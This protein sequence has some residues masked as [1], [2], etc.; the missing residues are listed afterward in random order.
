[1][2]IVC[3]FWYQYFSRRSINIRPIS[4]KNCA[5]RYLIMTESNEEF[6]V[7]IE[8]ILYKV[9]L[10]INDDYRYLQWTGTITREI[11]RIGSTRG[12]Y[13]S[14]IANI[15][16]GVAQIMWTCGILTIFD[17]RCAGAR[18]FPSYEIILCKVVMNCV[19]EFLQQSFVLPNKLKILVSYYCGENN[20]AQVTVL[21][22]FSI[23]CCSGR[24]LE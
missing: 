9:L 11:H 18:F 19:K 12:P 2:V 8:N 6:A 22:L 20:V 7:S 17:I 4:P 15:V 1:M 10:A 5:I 16:L 21:V 23:D 13:A 14:N 3:L 24:C